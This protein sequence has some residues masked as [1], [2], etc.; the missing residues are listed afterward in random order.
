[1]MKRC[2]LHH[3]WVIGRMTFIGDVVEGYLFIREGNIGVIF[4]IEPT[5]MNLE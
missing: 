2:S 3:G 1:M 4:M 5:D